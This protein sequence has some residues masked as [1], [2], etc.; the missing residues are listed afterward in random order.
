MQVQIRDQNPKL[1]K[2]IVASE[3]G[4]VRIAELLGLDR[5]LDRSLNLL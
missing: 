5:P 3:E 1:P 4:G 2:V